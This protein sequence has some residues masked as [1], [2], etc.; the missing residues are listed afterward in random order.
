MVLECIGWQWVIW[1]YRNIHRT[2]AGIFRYDVFRYNLF[3][4]CDIWCMFIIWYLYFFALHCRIQSAANGGSTRMSD[5]L[6]RFVCSGSFEKCFETFKYIYRYYISLFKVLIWRYLKSFEVKHDTCHHFPEMP[7]LWLRALEFAWEALNLQNGTPDAECG[8]T[9]SQ[10][11][12]RLQYQDV[13]GIWWK[14][15][16]QNFGSFEKLRISQWVSRTKFP[17]AVWKRRPHLEHES[18]RTTMFIGTSALERT[19]GYVW[20]IVAICGIMLQ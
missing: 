2:E 14:F 4:S 8:A 7:I 16:F 6:R 5:G 17:D 1:V 15:H 9:C 10:S 18:N 12:S 13:I 19:S 3:Q 11:K 20:H